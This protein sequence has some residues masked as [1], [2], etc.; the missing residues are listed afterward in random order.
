MKRIS[1]ITIAAFVFVFIFGTPAL[2]AGDLVNG[3]YG[4]YFGNL[5][6][7]DSTDQCT[8]WE[9]PISWPSTCMDFDSSTDL[10]VNMDSG[11]DDAFHGL[12]E[13]NPFQTIGYAISRIPALRRSADVPVTIHVAAGLYAEN[14]WLNLER[15]RIEGPEGGPKPVITGTA[16]DMDLLTIEGAAQVNL[17]G[18]MFQNGRRGILGRRGAGFKL[19][20]CV[21]Q[22]CGYRGI[23]VDEG[24]WALLRN[25]QVTG[26]GN[27]GLSVLRNSTVS[28]QGSNQFNGNGRRG[29]NIAITSSMVAADE[30]ATAMIDANDN[31]ENGISVNT[32]SS[33]TALDASIN[34]ASNGD[35]GVIAFGG[36]RLVLL[37]DAHVNTSGNHSR[38]MVVGGASQLYVNQN[39]SLTISNNASYGMHV[40]LN[41]AAEIAGAT[42]IASNQHIG[43]IVVYAS[44]VWSEAVINITGNSGYGLFVGRASSFGQGGDGARMEIS[45]TAYKN[46]HNPGSGMGLYEDSAIRMSSGDLISMSNDGAGIEAGRGASLALRGDGRVDVASNAGHGIRIN[47]QSVAKMDAAVM[48][49]TGNGGN[50]LFA[51]DASVSCKGAEITG[52]TNIDVELRF[53]TRASL[54]DNTVGTLNDDGTV[55]MRNSGCP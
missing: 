27:D 12:T 41:G 13:S 18:L 7:V 43:I 15:V 19:I 8:K 36:S 39:A 46:D 44:S 10:Y 51:D 6:V 25:V 24:T 4:K 28:L 45:A 3:C 48:S 54:C 49:I 20:D 2:N 17:V 9:Y 32:S 35:N 33:L 22:N 5:R 1:F 38:G 50:G 53:G 16:A 30:A 37:D 40:T 55:L 34:T 23:Q 42:T 31:S 11:V 47:M 29:I 14:L 21:V 52:N 26:C